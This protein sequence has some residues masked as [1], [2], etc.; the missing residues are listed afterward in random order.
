MDLFIYEFGANSNPCLGELA[1]SAFVIATCQRSVVLSATELL[2]AGAL[3]SFSGADAYDYF[4][5]FASGLESQIKGETDVFGQV[6]SAFKKFAKEKPD[7]FATFSGLFT[8][9]L[10]DTKEI[11]ATYLHGIGGNT[12]GALARRLLN[13]LPTDR[14]LLIGAGQVSKSVAPYFADAH[15]TIYNRSL[16]R[17]LE[18]SAELT[19]KGYEGIQY[20]N[21]EP[22]PTKLIEDATLI[23]ICTPPGSEL[24]QQVIEHTRTSTN[25]SRIFHFGAQAMDLAAFHEATY[26]QS[27]VFSLTEL[28][29][30]EKSQNTLRDRQVAQALKACH[31]RAILRSMSRS[32]HIAHG[33]EDLPAF[34]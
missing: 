12:Y 29:E 10:E 6:K 5:R 34:Y 15:L 16:P 18:L 9:V 13:P 3:R 7:A 24:D 20:I 31:D 2:V 30:M 8:R 33:W 11:R 27:R 19:Q 23:L 14:V 4:L 28:F 21:K 22:I 25:A 17:L 1:E 32:I 26:L